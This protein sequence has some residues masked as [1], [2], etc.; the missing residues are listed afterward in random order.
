MPSSAPSTDRP[1][2]APTAVP[3]SA[4]V[5]AETPGINAWRAFL[6]AHARVTRRLDEE[7]QASHGLSLAEY[8]A[9]LQVAHA[10]GRRIRM[11]VLADRVILSRSGITRLVDRLEAAGSVERSACASDAR[12]QEAVLTPAGLS[13]LRAAARTHLDGVQRYFLDRLDDRDLAGLEESL[14]RVAD[15]LGPGRAGSPSATPGDGDAGT[16][17]DEHG[18]VAATAQPD[19]RSVDA[20]TP[21]ADARSVD[22]PD[23]RGADAAAPHAD[24]RRAV[25]ATPD[26]PTVRGDRAP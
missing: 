22:A 21:G 8:D 19:A 5:V 6:Q 18:G 4:A 25:A 7:L 1:A 14:G 9:L 26:V 2:D 11:N 13:R 10:P 15:P 12:G 20:A 24:S 16:E 23:T 17:S 3:A